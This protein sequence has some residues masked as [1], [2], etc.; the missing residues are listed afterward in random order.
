MRPLAGVAH[1]R[2]GGLYQAFIDITNENA[3]SIT[4][5]QAGHPGAKSSSC[6][7][8]LRATNPQYLNVSAG[9]GNNYSHPHPEVLE[10]AAD[11]GAAILPTD[12]PGT[13]EVVADGEQMWWKSH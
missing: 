4:Q 7:P 3:A 5:A 8:F 9:E 13:I 10:R 1:K 6:E 11:V 2:T 12:E